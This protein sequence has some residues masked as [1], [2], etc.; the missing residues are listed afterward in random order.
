MSPEIL[1]F[2]Y[3]FDHAAMTRNCDGLTHEESVAAP[4]AGNCANWVLG[5][6][7]QNRMAVLR[8]LGEAP[9][10]SDEEGAI[11]A[12]GA[13]SFD[14]AEARDFAGMLRDLEVTQER[15]R[16]GLARLRPEA[17]GK[18]LEPDDKW[19]FAE[20]LHFMSFHESYHAGQLGLLRRIAGKPG[21]I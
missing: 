18:K 20:T 10:W 16:A 15:I 6:I 7:L 9:V 1:R 21:A 17:L 19:T 14:P 13:T 11:Y 12:R 3:D 5:H 2:L 8:M 4:I